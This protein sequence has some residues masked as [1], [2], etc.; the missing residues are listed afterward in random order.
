MIA[1]TRT[2]SAWLALAPL[3]ALACGQEEDDDGATSVHLSATMTW[4]GGTTSG[5]GSE[6]SSGSEG[7]TGA[8]EGS[9]G[10]ASAS[11]GTTSTTSAS[12]SD[13]TAT[14]TTTTTTT[15]TSTSTT[16]DPPQGLCEPAGNIIENG[17]L[18]G[19]M[20]GDAPAG[21]EVRTPGQVG[22]CEGSGPH[23]WASDPA[24]GCGG[25]AI[26]IDA[27]DIWDCYAV[28]TVSPYNSIEGGATYII[29]ATV[30]AQGNAVNPAAWFVV[31]AQWLDQ[32]D[33]FFGDEKNPKTNDAS[34]NDFDWKVLEW[35][36]VAPDNA[37]RI[38]VWMTAH[39]P[40]QVE[41]DHVAVIKKG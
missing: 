32:N 25:G 31:G 23:M 5:G 12:T 41:Y 11:A 39:Y 34:E 3:V 27:N 35:E 9:T 15:T 13:G 21:W 8:T 14:T 4:T 22:A 10:A 20:A 28:Q 24:P 29:R 36:L 33:A 19:G 17:S 30:R 38:L 26:T 18:D 37:R 40:G 1:R 2:I 7:S 6:G 16:G